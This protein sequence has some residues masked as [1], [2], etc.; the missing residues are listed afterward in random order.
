MM[1][2]GPG[3]G[4]MGWSH[5]LLLSFFN[6]DVACSCLSVLRFLIIRALGNRRRLLVSMSN[7]R[8]LRL[9]AQGHLLAADEASS[10][11]PDIRSAN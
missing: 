4:A 5:A 8:S 9:V 3:E 11:L 7:E 6:L 1:R 2:Y 10:H